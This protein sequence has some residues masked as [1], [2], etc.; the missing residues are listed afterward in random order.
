MSTPRLLVT[1]SAVW[2]LIGCGTVAET[3]RGQLLLF[4]EQRMAE[5][6]AQ[7]YEEACKEHPIV[8]GT[9]DAQMVERVGQRIAASSGRDFAWEFRLLNAPDVVN[10]FCLPGGKVAVY[11]GILKVTQN[12]DGLAAVIG[13]E[14]A[15]ATSRH[16]NERMTQGTAADALLA[17]GSKLLNLTEL[18]SETKSWVMTALNAGASVGVLLPYSRKHE[19]E[20]DEIGLLFLV[21]AGYD[22]EE[23]PRLWE[24]MAAMG[25][26]GTFEF[27]STHP[28]PE[29]RAKRL[30][31]LIPV[32]QERVA[33]EQAK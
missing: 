1:F 18:K 21:R 20:A 33:R 10:A 12:E 22:P 4:D 24:R 27:L 8:R 9:P 29:N 2:L 32:M 19:T 5:L 11:S 23:A 6:G 30:R 3:G 17:G 15:H 31:E 16:G 13:H 25:G 26:G 14:V 28:S 7:A